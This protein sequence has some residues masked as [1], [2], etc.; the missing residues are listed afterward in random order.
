VKEA[1][2]LQTEKEV[3]S[4]KK[5]LEVAERKVKDAPDDL[6]AVVEGKFARSLSV[7][8][9]AYPGSFPDFSPL[10]EFN[11]KE[12]EDTLKKELA[13]TKDQVRILKK[14]TAEVREDE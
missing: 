4:L 2:A 6:H 7:D 3:A 12:T 8:S 14:R 11:T 10:D 1:M 5:N 9:K 13:E